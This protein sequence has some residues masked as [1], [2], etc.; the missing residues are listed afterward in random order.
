LKAKDLIVPLLHQDGSL[1]SN[2]A[3]FWCA[4]NLRIR[5][6]HPQEC[7]APTA[8]GSKQPHSKTLNPE[9]ISQPSY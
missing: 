5:F 2:Y 6:I 8:M 1:Q 3:Y 4:Y 7:L 9:S